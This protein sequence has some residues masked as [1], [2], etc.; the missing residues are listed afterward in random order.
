MPLASWIIMIIKAGSHGAGGPRYWT[1][2][3][4]SKKPARAPGLT[5]VNARI[6]AI[7]CQAERVPVTAPARPSVQEV[8]AEALTAQGGGSLGV[9]RCP[10]SLDAL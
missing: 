4:S 3:L 7:L 2:R 5:Q 8:P 1:A 10:G 6:D 9:P